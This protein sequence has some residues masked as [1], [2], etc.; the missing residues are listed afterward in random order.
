MRTRFILLFCVFHSVSHQAQHSQQYVDSFAMRPL[1]KENLQKFESLLETNNL[2]YGWSKYHAYHGYFYLVKSQKDSAAFHSKKAITLYQESKVKYPNEEKSLVQAY[3]VLGRIAR[4]VGDYAESNSYLLKALDI[5]IEYNV[6]LKSYIVASIAS[7]H[8]ALGNAKQAL[9]YYQRNIKDSIFIKSAQAEITTLTRIGVLYSKTY[10]NQL[11]SSRFYFRKAL[12][13]SHHS[14]YKNNLPFIYGNIADYFRAENKDSALFYY[15]KSKIAFEGFIEDPNSS[16]NNTDYYQLI[17]NSFVDIHE[18]KVDMAIMSLNIIIDSL[19]PNV[20]DKNDRD[21]LSVAYENLVIALESKA[22]YKDASEVLKKQ[23][24]FEKEFDKKLQLQELEK[25]QVAYETSKREEQI[26][27]L[28]EEA[29]KSNTILQ[30]QKTILYGAIGLSFLVLTLGRL[31]YKQ[32]ILTE[33]FKQVSLEQ[34]L[35]R[36]QMNPHFLFNALNTASLLVDEK[37]DRAK[38]YIQKLAKLL[39]LTL[40]NSRDDFVPL[41]NE[42]SALESYLELQSNFS[43]NFDYEIKIAEKID[44]QFAQIPP[45]LIQPFIE[46]AIIHGISKSDVRGNIKIDLAQGVENTLVCTVTDNGVGY[47]TAKAKEWL[48]HKSLSL[49][50][51][52]ERLNIYQK[53][54]KQKLA[55]KMGSIPN[56]NLKNTGTQVIFTIPTYNL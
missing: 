41:E 37:A 45:M 2:L 14:D 9:I 22:Y 47:D 50:I 3:F 26:A 6:L 5:A 16:P 7:N 38:T 46:N 24:A 55:F 18:E 56:N 21:I 53:K 11:D 20:I 25:L 30:Q 35:L 1:N 29:K 33:K 10:L 13:R 34:R 19:K 43:K 28:V 44:S 27:V 42:L 12:K 15:K 40:E 49:K 17:N 52:K 48:G 32:R 51:V 23:L 4:E 54:N 36:S 8:L 31:F 39:R